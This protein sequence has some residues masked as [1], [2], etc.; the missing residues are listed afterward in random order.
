MQIAATVLIS[1]FMHQINQF[2]LQRSGLHSKKTQK[3]DDLECLRFVVPLL[4][5]DSSSEDGSEALT[6]PKG[7]T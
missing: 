6:Q 2:T 7:K 4:V 1:A 5:T 3:W